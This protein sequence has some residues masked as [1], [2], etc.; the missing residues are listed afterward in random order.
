M[1]NIERVESLQ[2]FRIQ[3]EEPDTDTLLIDTKTL[4]SNMSFTSLDMTTNNNPFM[5]E[6]STPTKLHANDNSTATDSSLDTSNESQAENNH[7]DT[8]HIN[9]STLHHNDSTRSVGQLANGALKAAQ[10]NQ[11]QSNAV[12]AFLSMPCRT[13]NQLKTVVPYLV[14]HMIISVEERVSKRLTTKYKVCLLTVIFINKE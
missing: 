5:S 10:A 11:S 12:Y 7:Q 2:R 14:D 3:T 1:E 13:L 6:P 9:S 8:N 4:K